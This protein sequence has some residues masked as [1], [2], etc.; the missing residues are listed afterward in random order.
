[1]SHCIHQTGP[2]LKETDLPVSWVLELKAS[3]TMHSL[4]IILLSKS[5]IFP[6][7]LQLISSSHQELFSKG[8]LFKVFS[9]FMLL[10]TIL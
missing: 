6:S 8:G 4:Q 9:S 1:M 10:P 5:T 7:C 2:E 3:T